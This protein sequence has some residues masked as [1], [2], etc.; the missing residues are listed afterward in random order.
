MK[1]IES[2]DEMREYSQQLKRDGKTI[3]SVATESYLHDGHM[4]LVKIAKENSDVV[5]LSN[6]HTF[7]YFHFL[8]NPKRYKKYIID[9]REFFLKQDIMICKENNVDVFFQ[10]NMFDLYSNLTNKITLSSPL[11][12]RFIKERAW[13]PHF[14]NGYGDVVSLYM[15]MNLKVFNIVSPNV[16]LF[17]EKDIYETTSYVKSLIDDLNYPIKLIVAP[18]IRDSNGLALS[19]RNVNLTEEERINAS[20]IYK[21]LHEVSAW[22]S[23]PPIQTIKTYIEERI[24]S[25]GG[26]VNY[27]DIC[28]AE[29]LDE[30]IS[31]DR[32]AVILVSV[33]F[34][35]IDELTE[36]TDNIVIKP[37]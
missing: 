28:C 4:S 13:L 17:G 35:D 6:F 11:I 7:I 31:I 27:I 21:T 37:K 24:K 36:L 32:K 10:P 25:F 18:T 12:D 19:S 26:I 15:L 33:G 34:G 14:S 3:A 2:I 5:V 16:C 8:N 23:Y 22:A 29:T 1:I 20:S 30:L 9:Y